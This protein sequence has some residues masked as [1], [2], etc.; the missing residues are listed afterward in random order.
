LPSG[1]WL[2]RR[3][4]DL[5]GFVRWAARAEALPE[6]PEPAGSSRE[7]GGLRWLVS[8]DH[9]P[10]SA[11]SSPETGGLHWLVSPDHLDEL[12]HRAPSD[13]G[14]LAWLLRPE[15]VPDLRKIEKGERP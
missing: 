8:P 13:P 7:T 10:E 15:P 4:R 1:N 9:L 2:F 3:L 12:P 11:G 6:A 14:W 5:Q